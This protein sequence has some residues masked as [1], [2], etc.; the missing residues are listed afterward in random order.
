MAT[1]DVNVATQHVPA[2]L[3]VNANTSVITV[4]MS[5]APFAVYCNTWHYVLSKA[6][7]VCNSM[8]ESFAKDNCMSRQTFFHLPSTTDISSN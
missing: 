3:K 2:A 5:T 4:N 6:E 7:R 1:R 8:L